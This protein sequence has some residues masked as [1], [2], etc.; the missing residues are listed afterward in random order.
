MALLPSGKKE[1]V[2][3]LK[4]KQIDS[5]E[6]REALYLY[7]LRI[8]SCIVRMVINKYL[9]SSQVSKSLD[10]KVIVIQTCPLGLKI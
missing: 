8:Y 5:K 1:G 9:Q 10:F 6:E 3:I 7:Y 2:F 4:Y